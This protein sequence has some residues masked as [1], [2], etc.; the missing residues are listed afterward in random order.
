MTFVR[1]FV[2]SIFALF[3]FLTP[4]LADPALFR[5]SDGD[6]TIYVLGTVHLLRSD[7]DWR[8]PAIDAALE[9]SDAV[10]FEADV[11]GADDNDLQNMVLRYGML[12]RGETLDEELSA[13]DWDE[14]TAYAATVGLPP[15]ALSPMRPWFAAITLTTFAAMNEGLDPNAG[16]DT[17]LYWDLEGTAIER[18][19]F[20]T[21]QQQTRFLAD[22]PDDIQIQFLMESVEDADA[23]QQD[24]DDI[25]AAWRAGNMDRIDA[26]TNGAMRATYPQVYESVIAARNRAWADDLRDLM[27]TPGTFFVAVGAAHLPGEEGLLNLLRDDGFTVMRQ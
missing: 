16:V 8:T 11:H 24:L 17:S 9:A 23:N 6:T 2:L 25:I 22:L 4:A 14:V 21:V 5:V 1:A 10:Y 27:A 7:E 13:S 12:P 20:E 3:F 19:Y 15:E 18:R 26:L